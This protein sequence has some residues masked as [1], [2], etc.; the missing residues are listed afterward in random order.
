MRELKCDAAYLVAGDAA[1]HL[2]AADNYEAMIFTR[3]A[4][5]ALKF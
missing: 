1:D 3:S 2:A 4:G 5:M